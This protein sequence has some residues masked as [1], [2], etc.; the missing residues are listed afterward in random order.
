MV[1]NDDKNN[2]LRAIPMAVPLNALVVDGDNGDVIILR[3]LN[4]TYICMQS[5]VC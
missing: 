1:Q 5:H 3:P 4:N 2:A